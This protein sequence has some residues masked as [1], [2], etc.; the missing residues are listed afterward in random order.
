M[1]TK[2]E[3][4]RPSHAYQLRETSTFTCVP[5]ERTS[6]FACIPIEK[7]I[8]LHMRT[9]W[10]NTTLRM[11]NN[12]EKHYPSHAYQYL[13]GIPPFIAYQLKHHP[14]RKYQGLTE[15]PHFIVKVECYELIPSKLLYKYTKIHGVIYHTNVSLIIHGDE[16]VKTQNIRLGTQIRHINWTKV[17]NK[18]LV[19]Y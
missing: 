8:T 7:N 10:E 11:H 19:K 1:H 13:K 6:P 9:N 5:I 18:Y 3:K 2:W 14:S 16:N 4:H 15:T 12:W 17:G